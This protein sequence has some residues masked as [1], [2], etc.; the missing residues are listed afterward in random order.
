[1]ATNLVT[2]DVSEVASLAEKLLRLGGDSLNRAVVES[3][4]SVIDAG[5]DLSRSRMSAGID[6]AE[7]FMRDRM[8]VA[9]ASPSSTS[10]SIT[11][12][13]E[14]TGL[15]HFHP[16]QLVQGAKTASKGDPARGIPSGQKAAG[17]NVTVTRGATKAL[18]SKRVFIAPDIKDS[19]GNPFVMRR[20]P[21]ATRT[22][23][24]RM[25]RVL[26]PAV[27]QLFA[28]QLPTIIPEAE[29]A[30][31]QELLDNAERSLIEG[32]T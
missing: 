14:Q 19:E 18:K 3:L 5:Y 32:L 1:M 16:V 12:V 21:G 28:H 11:A 30:L 4:N 27:Y 2:V 13:G 25:Q 29:E 7:S 24:T 8:R 31:M 26:G 17:V 20:L 22:G 6:V 9:H 23:K 15:S 10:A